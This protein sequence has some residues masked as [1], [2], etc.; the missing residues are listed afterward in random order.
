MSQMPTVVRGIIAGTCL[1]AVTQFVVAADWRQWRGPGRDAIVTPDSAPTQW[2]KTLTSV[3][4]QEAG[5]GH[6]SAVVV[7]ERVDQF[8]RV[9]DREVL[10][11]FELNS[12]R[13][14]W[15]AEA[16]W[17]FRKL[18]PGTRRP[19]LV[20]LQEFSVEPAPDGLRIRFR[21]PRGSY[22]TSLLREFMKHSM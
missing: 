13:K 9:D 20:R 5:E 4:S 7:G 15:S 8:A 6:S 22:A 2:P 21:L 19:S 17:Q 3:W 16:F 1:V 11:A 10:R 18:T 14:L 12:E